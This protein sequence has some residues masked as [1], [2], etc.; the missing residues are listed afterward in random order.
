MSLPQLLLGGGV[1]FLLFWLTS[2]PTSPV[3]RRLPRRTYKT[4]HVVPHVKIAHK[5][6]QY[7]IHHWMQL[8]VV[9]GYLWLRKRHLLRHKILHG[10]IL[11]SILQGLS[12]KDRF[13][14]VYR[15]E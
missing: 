2:H 10:F 14:I 11:G 12:Y 5:N 1:G 9:Y 4:H 7:H 8:L 15:Q 13:K 3:H 6:R